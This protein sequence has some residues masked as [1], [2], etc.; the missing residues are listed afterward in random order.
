[1]SGKTR[2]LTEM[3]DSLS[4]LLAKARRRPVALSRNGKATA[5]L[6]SA[7]YYDNVQE[8]MERALCCDKIVDMYAE[9][10]EHEAN[11]DGTLGKKASLKLMAD[12]AEV[13][14]AEED[15]WCWK[16]IEEAEKDGGLKTLSVE[17]SRKLT[18]EVKKAVAEI[19]K[20]T[21][22]IKTPKAKSATT[23]PRQAA[24][25]FPTQDIR[26]RQTARAG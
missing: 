23:P 17:E 4:P 8:I 16:M 2:A 21:P 12:I 25:V 7:R 22:V 6:V 19:G 13:V 3:P 20:K 14:N 18:E 24:H 5:F 15:R 26:K 1:M 10:L 9:R 11:K